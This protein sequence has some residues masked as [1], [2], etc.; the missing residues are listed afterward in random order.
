MAPCRSRELKYTSNLRKAGR[1]NNDVWGLNCK[2]MKKLRLQRPG[3]QLP[4][5]DGGS[6]GWNGNAKG[7]WGAWQN[8][9]SSPDG[10]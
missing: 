7:L 3:Q 4:W 6:C 1:W 2:E 8:S 9:A 10:W 5:E